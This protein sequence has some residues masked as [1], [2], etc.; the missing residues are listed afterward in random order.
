MLENFNPDNTNKIVQKL[1][2]AD[3]IYVDLINYEGHQDSLLIA[4]FQ[5]KYSKVEWIVPPRIWW[6]GK[7]L[8]EYKGEA[9]YQDIYH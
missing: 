3:S 7:F 1:P 8:H 2:K 6:I 9:H 5:R 4:E